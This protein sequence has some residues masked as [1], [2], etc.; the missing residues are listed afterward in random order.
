M[1]TSKQE[2]IEYYA[3]TV[4]NLVKS[5]TGVECITSNKSYAVWL[6]GLRTFQ[7]HNPERQKLTFRPLITC[8]ASSWLLTN[9]RETIRNTTQDP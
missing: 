4:N 9:C 3:S 8:L 7:L 5:S 1:P 6:R 2:S